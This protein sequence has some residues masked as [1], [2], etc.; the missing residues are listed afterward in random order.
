MPASQPQPMTDVAKPVADCAAWRAHSMLCAV[1]T[2][3]VHFIGKASAKVSSI[4]TPLRITTSAPFEAGR[5]QQPPAIAAAAQLVVADRDVIEVQRAARI[6]CL[7][8]HF[9]IDVS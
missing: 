8:S 1:T 5:R 2:M 6:D 3:R 9:S 4:V 7:R